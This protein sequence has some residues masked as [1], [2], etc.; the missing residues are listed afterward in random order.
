MSTSN[1]R[2][3]DFGATLGTRLGWSV[4]SPAAIIV[5]VFFVTP[6]LYFLKFSLETPSQT[7][8]STPTLTF[9]NFQEFFASAYYVHTL[10][11]TI[12]IAVCSTLF[13]LILALPV[14][15]LITRSGPRVKSLLI[16]ATVFP[17]LVGNVVRSIGWVALLGYDGVVNNVLLDL[18]FI[19]E[20]LSLLHTP[21]TVGIAISSVVL[22]I[23][24][25][26]LQ[27]SMES[28]APSSEQAALSLGARPARVFRQITFPQMMPG[29]VAGTSLVFV[30]CINSYATPLLVGGSQV[31]ML[32]PA[33]YSA[34][35]TTNNW[36]FGAAM[37]TILLVVCLTVVM[38]YGRLVGRAFDAWRKETR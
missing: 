26:T 19:S 38:L 16:I 24:V 4:I 12:I 13:A 15:N 14:A 34:I 11:R 7:Q 22:P 32:A 33:I 35:T 17:L 5:L 18:G 30:L 9:E 8:I 37:A 3:R 20:P 36:P 25:L 6:I 21:V 10:I 1:L 23:M 31:P 27:A 29:V 28:I 2:D